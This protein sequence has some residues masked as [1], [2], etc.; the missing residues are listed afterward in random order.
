MVEEAAELYAK[1][2]RYDKLNLLHQASGEWDKA[3]EVA[4]KH[5]RIH[6][7][8]TYFAYAQHLEGMQDV[9]GCMKYYELADA[10]RSEV[11]RVLSQHGLVE[12]LQQYVHNAGDANLYRWYAQFL[13]S[14]SDLDG[15]AS[16]YRKAE[17]HLSLCRIACFAQGIEAA[18]QICTD[19]G[20]KSACY[21]LARHLE[22]DGRSKEA[23]HF[24][25]L[26]GRVGHAL[27]LAQSQG[28]DNELMHLA[29]GSGN[30]AQMIQAGRYCEQSGQPQ[31]AVTLY[32]K[33]GSTARALEL[34]FSARLFDQLRKI[35]EDLRPDSGLENPE[36]LARV[37]EF[38]L[39]NQQHEKAIH[40]LGM[41]KQFETAVDLCS[42]HDVPI[43]EDMAER[44]T[45]DKKEMEASVR[46][47]LLT[48]I[49]KLC[50]KQGK[51]QLACTKYTQAGDKSRAMKALLQSGDTEKIIFFAGTARQA[52]VYLL[53]ANYLQSLDWHVEDVMKNI[54][55]FYTK[56]KEFEKLGTFY[57]HCAQAEIDEYRDYEKAAGALKEALKYLKKE[58]PNQPPVD[59][60]RLDD[61]G[62]RIAY[63]EK[64]ALARKK[65]GPQ[66]MAACEELLGN[67]DSERGV[68]VGD[69]FALM[70]EYYY[71][72]SQYVEA[73]ESIERM[74]ERRIILEP[75][76][77]RKMVEHIYREVGQ[78]LHNA[79]ADDDDG[80]G[81]EL[82]EEIEEDDDGRV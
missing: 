57:E 30:Q 70:V 15:A 45:P 11:P 54:I 47:D 67:P 68:R 32:H 16:E 18:Q 3:V 73:Y 29:L 2:G 17:D 58:T 56:A 6:L 53:A 46:N 52:D 36:I 55:L 74:V 19:S 20:S 1:C 37:G 40:I 39:Q 27:R 34:C 63:I 21:H 8:G 81:E 14:K 28:L 51:F 43:T 12:E 44:M 33:A 13:E 82:D 7:L 71:S 76:L 25:S 79:G 77:D 35:A 24:Y 10:A 31:K 60:S 48:R 69:I 61:I 75:Y 59:P 23:I 78:P 49:A 64:F 65:E 5:D 41:S 4:E 38:F 42:T 66:M 62:Q 9:A 50:K 72:Q 80:V 26:S 22:A